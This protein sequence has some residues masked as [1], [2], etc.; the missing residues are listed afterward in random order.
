MKNRIPIEESLP[1]VVKFIVIHC[2]AAH[3][4]DRETLSCHFYIKRDGGIVQHLELDTIGHH[5]AGF[6]RCSIAICYEGGIRKDGLPGDTRTYMQRCAMTDLIFSLKATF[7]ET[8]VVGHNQL[9][10]Y[11]GVNACPGIKVN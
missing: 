2:S 3:Y 10:A 1:R 5:A 9:S 8:K 6:N 11:N 4:A 7:P